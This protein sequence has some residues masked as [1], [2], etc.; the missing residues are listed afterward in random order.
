MQEGAPSP[1]LRGSGAASYNGQGPNQSAWPQ[2]RAAV[3]GC[4]R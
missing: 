3:A 1:R 4:L 2:K